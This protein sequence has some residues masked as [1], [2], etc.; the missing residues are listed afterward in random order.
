MKLKL[1]ATILALVVAACS[2]INQKSSNDSKLMVV[3]ANKHATEAGLEILRL[4]G[5]AVD[6]AVAIEAVLSLVEPQSSGLAGGAVMVYFDNDI[7]T[8]SVYDGRET[9]PAA[10]S[11]NMF[12]DLEGNPMGFIDAKTSGLSTG[13]PGAVA[14]LSL[15]HKEHG[16]LEW[17]ELFKNAHNLAENGFKVSPRLN[18]MITNFGRY[19][20]NT[21]EE[22]PLDAFRYF[23][24][25]TGDPLPVGYL[26]K[27]SRYAE[28]LDIIA[29]NPNSM[30]EG[31]LAAQIVNAVRREP[32][33]GDMTIDD[34]AAYKPVKR[35]ALCTNYRELQICSAP[36]PFSGVAVAQVMA[37]LNKTDGFSNKGADD[38]S[39]WAL[40][41]EAQRLAYSDRD[42]YVADPDRVQ[43]PTQ[44][45][46]DER[47]IANRA[48]LISSDAP[49]KSVEPGNPWQYEQQP[50]ERAGIDAT[51]DTPG[52]THFVV[53]DA[54]GDVVSMTASVESIFG[55]TR[56]VGG[57]FLNNQ[58]T[59]F[60]FMPE[61]AS[62][63]PIANAVAP[64]KRPR[65]S[66]SP[67]IVLDANGEFLMA[68]GS[69]GGSN[70][71]AYVTKSLVGVLDWGL[72]PQ[73]AVALPNMVARKNLVRLE[74]GK[75]SDELIASMEAFGFT[76]DAT[77][78]ENSGLSVVLRKENGE[79]V[80]GV[81]PRREGVV[82]KLN[83][84]EIP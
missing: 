12:L 6:A 43:L 38:F 72:S 81:D 67:T 54:N 59:D 45:L 75:V 28:T 1:S 53:V 36:P 27:N 8:L 42:Q 47:Y 74:K 29:S 52:T 65:S 20:P 26:L 44:G 31:D 62:G 18:R 64:N 25:D 79:L 76:V 60:S 70:I 3:S 55:S 35:Q 14:M 41:A 77:G 58:L 21:I 9:S 71:I 51:L 73:D 5:S 17:S 10:T 49:M 19:I 78:G 57:M 83:N 23:F 68:T 84:N 40:L 37:I 4:G 56:M 46:L 2:V 66:M 24:T 34:L 15:A 39:N 48:G 11:P 30:Y 22:G 80:G 32:R 16:L 7:K 63:Q 82:G 69:P 50:S 61:D 33:P 13:V